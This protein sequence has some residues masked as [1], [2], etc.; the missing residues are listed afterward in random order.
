MGL[1]FGAGGG[2]S[3]IGFDEVAQLASA[4]SKTKDEVAMSFMDRMTQ[5]VGHSYEAIWRGYLASRT[6]GNG[7]N[8]ADDP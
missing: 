7:K 1:V 4:S 5:S 8:L 6:S 3:V 2:G